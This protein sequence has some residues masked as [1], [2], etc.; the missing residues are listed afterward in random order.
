MTH[1]LRKPLLEHQSDTCV[2]DGH[3]EL[4]HSLPSTDQIG[5]F[6]WIFRLVGW[7]PHWIVLLRSLKGN[8]GKSCSTVA[9][10]LDIEVN[11]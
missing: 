7:L 1:L 10:E 2:S 3:R 5:H 6:P 4:T 8:G 9:P 11:P